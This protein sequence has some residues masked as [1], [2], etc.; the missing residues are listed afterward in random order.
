MQR[1]AAGLAA[2]LQWLARGHIGSLC[3]TL[4]VLGLDDTGWSAHDVIDMLDR[5]NVQLGLYSLTG[6]SQRDPLAL[7]AHLIQQ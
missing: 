6:G 3:R 5:R 1:L 7:F 4:T 2:R